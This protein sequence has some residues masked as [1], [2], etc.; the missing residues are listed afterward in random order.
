MARPIC[1]LTPAAQRHSGQ[2][3]GLTEMHASLI[4]LARDEIPKA[5]QELSF[6]YR[7]TMFETDL[8][9]Q[10]RWS[11]QSGKHYRILWT[12]AFKESIQ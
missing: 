1:I 9:S 5:G 10:H 8:P 2:S 12:R 7:V 6:E 3:S 4:A 11:P